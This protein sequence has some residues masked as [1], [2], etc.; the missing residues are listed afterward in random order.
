[1]PVLADPGYWILYTGFWILDVFGFQPGY[2]PEYPAA[3][4]E[5]F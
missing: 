5:W 1:V 4:K 3:N 2:I